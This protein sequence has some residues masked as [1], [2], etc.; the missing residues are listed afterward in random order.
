[1]SADFETFWSVYPRKVGK[2]M[3]RAKWKAITGNGLEARCK[4]RDGN[5]M[6]VELFAT[7]D[8]LIEG[9]KAYR[10]D[11]MDTEERYVAHP[12]TWLNQGRW[13][14]QDEQERAEKARKMDRIL[15]RLNTPKLRMVG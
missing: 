7:P 15:E 6:D 14:D 9:A 11:C 4:D 2:A 10:Y 12:T 5:V 13:E 3:A 8:D 1:M